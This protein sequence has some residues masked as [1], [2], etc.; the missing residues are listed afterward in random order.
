[1]V[2]PNSLPVVNPVA[3]TMEF[4]ELAGCT[5]E[6]AVIHVTRRHL[7][8]DAQHV[9]ARG[10]AAPCV[11]IGVARRSEVMP[12]VGCQ[13]LALGHPLHNVHQLA[14]GVLVRVITTTSF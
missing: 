7:L 11:W 9:L 10:I 2:L 3:T 6:R 5:I 4:A 14:F 8:A 12:A 1:M 13:V